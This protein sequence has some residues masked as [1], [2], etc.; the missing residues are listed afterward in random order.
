MSEDVETDFES[1]FGQQCH[2]ALGTTMACW[3]KLSQAD[4]R[5]P[6]LGKHCKTNVELT[7]ECYKCHEG[8]ATMW[9]CPTKL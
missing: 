1:T 5:L 8:F 7:I 9:D 2:E 3:T 6:M 4:V